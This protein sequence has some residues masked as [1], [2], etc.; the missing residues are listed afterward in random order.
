MKILQFTNEEDLKIL[1]TKCDKV[2][3]VE[4]IKQD[5]ENMFEFCDNSIAI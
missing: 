2:E 3:S 5:I 1:S 4:N